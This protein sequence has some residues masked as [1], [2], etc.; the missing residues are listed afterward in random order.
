MPA[1]VPGGR[2]LSDTVKA[3]SVA[4]RGASW[5]S[6]SSDMSSASE[7]RCGSCVTMEATS[8]GPHSCQCSCRDV[9]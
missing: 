5:G 8:S 1:A 7:P 2:F 9:M 6:M 3:V 4:R